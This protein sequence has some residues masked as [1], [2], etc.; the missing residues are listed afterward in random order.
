[1]AVKR[2]RNSLSQN[3]LQ[4]QHLA[5]VPQHPGESDEEDGL[6]KLEDT[7]REKGRLQVFIEDDGSNFHATPRSRKLYYE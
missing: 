4:Q 6:V 1:V 5:E 7:K 3:R 2:S